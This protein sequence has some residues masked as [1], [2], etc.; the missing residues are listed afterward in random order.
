M[1]ILSSIIDSIL[2]CRY[3]GL[4]DTVEIDSSTF[5]VPAIGFF[6]P[7]IERCSR[8]ALALDLRSLDF[9]ISSIA[10]IQ[11]QQVPA[12]NIN[13]HNQTKSVAGGR[14]YCFSLSSLAKILQY[15]HL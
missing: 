12:Q 1:Y 5:L 9:W 14:L 15:C 2:C 13:S 10:R 7:L 11:F 4:K 8:S 6:Y 3:S